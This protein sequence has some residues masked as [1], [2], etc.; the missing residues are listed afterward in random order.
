MDTRPSLDLVRSLTDEHVLRALMRHRRLTRAELAAETG[1]SKPTAGESVRRLTERGLVAD[2]GERT[3]GGRGR[4]RVGSYYS[5]AAGVGTALAV[6]IAPEGVV[7][8]CLDAYGD[9]VRRAERPARPEHVAE[10]LRE[11]AA[12]VG[13]QPRLA[14]VSAADPVDRATG[15]LVHLPDSPFLVGELDPATIL[16]G[17]VLVDNDV[18]WAAR[19]ERVSQGDDFAY[20]F[21]GAGLGCAIVGD[22]EIRRGRSGLAGEIAHLLTAGPDGRATPFIEVFAQLGLRRPGSTA[23]DVERLLAAAESTRDAIGRAVAGVVAAAV[24]LAD[25]GRVIVGGSWGP[26]LL[27]D[28]RAAV[29]E[30]PRGAPVEPATVTDQP[31]MAGA[32]AEAV[33]RLRA[34]IAQTG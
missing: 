15:R 19:A 17:P 12:E 29:G 23:I 13:G 4:G 25:P 22:G 34:L 1:I 20:L 11:V 30:L 26:G 28:I 8:E 6:S 10:A 14:V 32:R 33:S 3:P 7:A 31:S 9:T 16:G 5:L 18:N 2:T 21:L 24:T 27:P